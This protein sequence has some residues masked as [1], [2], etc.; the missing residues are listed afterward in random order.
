MQ[1]IHLKR[2][3][4]E[5]YPVQYSAEQY[6]TEQYSTEQ[7]SAVQNRA[8]QKGIVQ[9]SWAQN[10]TA[11]CSAEQYKLWLVAPAPTVNNIPLQL[12]GHCESWYMAL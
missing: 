11:Q 10:S 9:N 4:S 8:E 3:K 12:D 1:C 2:T 5:I 7:Y 6:D